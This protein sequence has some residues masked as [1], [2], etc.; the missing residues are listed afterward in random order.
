LAATDDEN[1]ADAYRAIRELIEKVVIIPKGGAYQ[2][3]DTEIHGQLA[4]F[5]EDS[6]RGTMREP[7]SMGAMVAGVGFEPTT[8]RL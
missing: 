3:Y 8:F 4:A 5:L 7:R 2:G 1:R 6:Q